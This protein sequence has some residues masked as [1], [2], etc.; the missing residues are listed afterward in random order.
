MPDCGA[1][2]APIRDTLNLSYRPSILE[3]AIFDIEMQPN[4]NGRYDSMQPN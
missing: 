1:A 4:Q 2:F 3:E